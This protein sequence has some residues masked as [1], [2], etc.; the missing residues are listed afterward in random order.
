MSLFKSTASSLFFKRVVFKFSALLLT[1]E[2]FFHVD[3]GPYSILIPV[4]TSR[5]APF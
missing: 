5:V 1:T 3:Y 2:R 4:L